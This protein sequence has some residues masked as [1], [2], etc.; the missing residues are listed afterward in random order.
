[1]TGSIPQETDLAQETYLRT[2]LGGS[3]AQSEMEVGVNVEGS[4]AK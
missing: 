4:W 1:M 3:R 2:E